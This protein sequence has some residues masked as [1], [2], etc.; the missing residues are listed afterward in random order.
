MCRFKV[1][2]S[3]GWFGVFDFVFVLSIRSK[4]S[5]EC[6]IKEFGFIDEGFFVYIVGFYVVCVRGSLFRG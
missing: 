3:D 1:G 6:N 4:D 5:F 2:G